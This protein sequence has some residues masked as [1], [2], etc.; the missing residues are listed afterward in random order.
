MSTGR[1]EG[2]S[3]NG[4]GVEEFV[5]DHKKELTMEELAGLQS[6]L[7]KVLKEEHPLTK[8]KTGRRLAVML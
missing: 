7:Q 1:S 5:D 4:A 2:L 6:E 3:I 8:R